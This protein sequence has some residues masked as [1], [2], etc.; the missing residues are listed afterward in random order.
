KPRPGISCL[1]HRLG[2]CL[3]SSGTGQACASA[4]KIRRPRHMDYCPFRQGPRFVFA[5][6]ET[7]CAPHQPSA[8]EY[9]GQPFIVSETTGN[10][11]EPNRQGRQKR[12]SDSHL[13]VSRIIY[14]K[15]LDIEMR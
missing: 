5:G 12:G 14:T 3:P 11:A 2:F 1:Q 10:L 15:L 13:T 6:T 4:E 7:L 8:G 9:V